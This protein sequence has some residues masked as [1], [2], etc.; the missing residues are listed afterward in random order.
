MLERDRD[1]ISK[2]LS[3]QRIFIGYSEIAGYCSSLAYSFNELGQKAHFCNL[4]P[5]KYYPAGKLT[6]IES[7]L[8]RHLRSRAG[9]NRVSSFLR[10]NLKK[11]L[12]KLLLHEMK[13]R[14]DVFIFIGT[15][16]PFFENER[17]LLKG[18]GKTIV[19]VFL[20]SDSRP[21]YL[22]ALYYDK[23]GTDYHEFAKAIIKQHEEIKRIE[24]GSDFVICHA[25]SAHFLSRP[26]V[27]F[28]ALGFPKVIGD[29]SADG[30]S[31][32][33]ENS[34]F[35]KNAIDETLKIL[36]APTAPKYKGSEKIAHIIEELREEGIAVK[37]KTITEKPNREV[38]QALRECDL[39][40]DELYSDTPLAGF[41]HEAGQFAKLP[42]VGSYAEAKDFFGDSIPPS[43]F[44]HPDEL[45]ENVRALFHDRG[46]LAE[47]GE[48][49]KE[50]ID[51]EW[52]P[53]AVAMRYIRLINNRGQKEWYTSPSEIRYVRGWGIE[54]RELRGKL[55]ALISNT[56]ADTLCMHEKPELELALLSFAGVL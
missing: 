25:L 50:F 24:D 49:L 29:N 40:I 7:M 18:I 31:Q 28:M 16:S 2:T 5:N 15:Y 54:E 52:N 1:E 3:S 38:I 37:L 36:H 43:M 12:L 53:A 41:A 26:F 55:K 48:A 46:A 23:Y 17:G 20:G 10:R 30:P 6:V 8:K 13:T 44:I 11:N 32:K 27:R 19:S 39:V 42:I 33:V 22:N 14:Y 4:L 47:K 45:K 34:V 9:K 35:G 51:T 56:G 21:L